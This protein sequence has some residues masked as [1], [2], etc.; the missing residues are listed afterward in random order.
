MQWVLFAVVGFFG[1]LIFT[2][3]F[4]LAMRWARS[5]QPI[6]EY[7]PK[8]HEHKRG[9]PTMGGAII[10]I[11]F[12]S[13]LLVYQLLEGALSVRELLLV[14]AT[15][16]FGLIG[17]L[18]D[19]I[20]FLQQHSQGLLARYKVLLQLL[21]AAGFL[22][23]LNAS[24]L[25]DSTIKVPFSPVEWEVSQTL[26]SLLIML[27]F[28][29]A[30]NAVNL[31]DGLD[32]LA[33]GVTLVLLTAYGVIT[34]GTLLSGDLFG[35]IVI[36]GAVLLGFL[37]FNVHPARI[38]LGDTGSFALGGFVAALSVFTRTELI[39]LVLAFVPVVEALSVIVQ[40]TSFRIFK[41]RIFKVSP[42]H[43][44]F[45]RAEGVTYEYL[46]PNVEWP[47]WAI[48]LLFWGVSALFAVIG[49]LAYFWR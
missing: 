13:V 33:V 42:L 43:H 22:T 39:L 14:G 3:F 32:G 12:L 8:I 28:V 49:L 15:L 23:A 9:T 38:F 21:V 37:W 40:V 27:V 47:E 11:V 44:H 36:F 20:K 10:L 30:V 17:L 35:L 19:V 6:R 4:I 25:L 5:G 41:R 48:T 46:L 26:L 2:H 18:D 31:T 29:G 24:G 1:A 7:G 34:S 45:E 16:G